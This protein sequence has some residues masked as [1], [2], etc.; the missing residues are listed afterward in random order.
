M[1]ANQTPPPEGMASPP[2]SAFYAGGEPVLVGD[3]VQLTLADCTVLRFIPGM[4]VVSIVGIPVEMG[5]DNARFAQIPRPEMPECDWADHPTDELQP[6]EKYSCPI[7]QE[8]DCN[9]K[10]Y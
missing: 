2:C 1:I 8:K 5:V 9:P 10:Y 7:C 4:V 6:K 3:R